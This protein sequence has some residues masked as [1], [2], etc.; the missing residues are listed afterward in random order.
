MRATFEAID[1][2][3]RLMALYPNHFPTHPTTGPAEALSAFHNN[4]IIS[5]LGIEGLHQ[6]GNSVSTLRAYQALGVQYATLTWNCHNAY[7]DAAVL[8]EISSDSMTTR[9]AEPHWHGLSARGRS[10]I[11][12]MNRLG[13]LIDLSHVSDDVMWEVLTGAHAH[14][15]SL[16]TTDSWSGSLAPP[17]FSHSSAR[18]LCAHPRNVPDALLPVIKARGAL[19]MINITPGFIS[20]VPAPADTPS[21]LPEPHEANNTLQQVV[22]H[23]VH[24]GSRI[25]Y[26]HVGIGTDFDGMEGAPRGLEDVSKIPALVA[27]M[28]RVGISEADAGK[29]VGGNLLRIWEQVQKTGA[30]L[31]R[32][33]M[34]PLEDEPGNPLEE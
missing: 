24:I 16:P 14:S 33:G 7:A 11:R 15:L 23:I 17:I 2:F 4:R 18:A 22:R 13:M 27:E 29:I 19:V 32:E 20:C 25:G 34:K 5:P 3:H 1:T 9:V 8:T 31:R 21:A 12:E 10:L 6:I 30:R 28:L 26:E